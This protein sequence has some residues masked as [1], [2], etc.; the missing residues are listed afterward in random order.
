M[1]YVRETLAAY[2]NHLISLGV[3]GMRLDT[4]K[5]TF[6]SFRFAPFRLTRDFSHSDINVTDL[7][8]ITSRLTGSPYITQEV[9]WGAGQ[10]VTPE[11]Y[12]GIGT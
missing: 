8:N 11:L 4:A 9:I 6:F 3:D 7:A 5:S 1:E 2:G 12:V 10:P